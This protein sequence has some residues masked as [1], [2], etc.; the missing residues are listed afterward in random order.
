MNRKK[1]FSEILSIERQR[2]I[3]LSSARQRK[4][5]ANLKQQKA[6]SLS[7]KTKCLHTFIF[8]AHGWKF[9][10]E[11]DEIECSEITFI[12]KIKCKCTTETLFATYI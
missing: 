11:L 2:K 1:K 7:E 6:Q 8:R 9:S 4:R 10:N 12:R 5:I 3:K